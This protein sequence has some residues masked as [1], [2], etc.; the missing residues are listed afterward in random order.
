[1]KLTKVYI[2]DKTDIPI[3]RFTHK[4]QVAI[5]N[6][7]EVPPLLY[8]SVVTLARMKTTHQRTVPIGTII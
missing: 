3:F 8:V 7:I 6:T 2:P 4:K 5:Y 1:M